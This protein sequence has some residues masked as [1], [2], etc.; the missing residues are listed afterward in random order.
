M[1]TPNVFDFDDSELMNYDSETIDRVLI[2]QP[3]LYMNHL[4][5]ARSLDAQ[6][7]RLETGRFSTGPFDEDKYQQGWA[8][9]LREV[10]AHLRQAEYIEGGYLLDPD[11]RPRGR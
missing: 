5:I 4:R 8:R 10:A 9:A 6:A 2:E 1:P 11:A 7:G 3:A